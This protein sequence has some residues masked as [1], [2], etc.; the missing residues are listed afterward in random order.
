MS[1]ATLETSG[2][3]DACELR[4]RKVHKD[5]E[6]ELAKYDKTSA[7]LALKPRPGKHVAVWVSALCGARWSSVFVYLFVCLLACLLACFFTGLLVCLFA[8]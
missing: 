8:H 4:F 7:R 3:I 2:W 5:L 6:V 1:Q